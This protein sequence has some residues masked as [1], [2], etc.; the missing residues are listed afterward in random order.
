EQRGDVAAGRV[1][2]EVDV[3][4]GV[5]AL[6]VQELGHDQVADGVVDGRTQ[7]HDALLQQPRID[8]ERTLPAVGLLDDDRNHVVLQVVAHPSSSSAWEGPSSVA[9]VGTGAAGASFEVTVAQET[10][11]SRAFDRMISPASDE[12]PP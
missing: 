12:T 4:V 3:L 8:V 9:S 5:L 11:R 2:V 10:S 1:D 7:E 6:Q